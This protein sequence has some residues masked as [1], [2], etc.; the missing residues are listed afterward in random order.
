MKRK[1][2]NIAAFGTILTLLLMGTLAFAFNVRRVGAEPPEP[3]ATQWIRTYGGASDDIA[4]FIVQTG[5]GGYALLGS[6]RSFGAGSVDL[7]L[8]KT[9]SA[10]NMQWNK[11]YG[12]TNDEYADSLVETSDGGYALGGSTTSFGAGGSD[13]WL[14]KIAPEAKPTLIIRNSNRRPG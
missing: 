14:I 11:T 3:P 2:E 6:T 9:D 7:W 1:F 13:A 10:G 4:Y 12:G 5:D 8:V